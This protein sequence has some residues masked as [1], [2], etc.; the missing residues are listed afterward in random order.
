MD[1]MGQY[2]AAFLKDPLQDELGKEEQNI[3]NLLYEQ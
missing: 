2:T 1:D 3:F